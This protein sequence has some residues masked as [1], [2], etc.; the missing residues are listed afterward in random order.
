MIPGRGEGRVRE[1]G[2]LQGGHVGERRGLA[3]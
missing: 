2:R 3:S 1:S